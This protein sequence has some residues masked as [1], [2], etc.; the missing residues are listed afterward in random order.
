MLNWSKERQ[1]QDVRSAENVRSAEYDV[2]VDSLKKKGL[3]SEPI[4]FPSPT[5]DD[6]SSRH[7]FPYEPSREPTIYSAIK[8]KK[9]N[10]PQD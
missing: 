1:S 6:L 3:L 4:I 2:V 10:F 9:A 7:L 8:R 5:P